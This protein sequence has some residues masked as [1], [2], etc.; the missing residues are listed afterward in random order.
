[1]NALAR[2]DIALGAAIA[3]VLDAG[4][5]L[6]SGER[7]S[8]LPGG[9]AEY[10]SVCGPD[11]ARHSGRRPEV[12]AAEGAKI[13]A[14]K[15]ALRARERAAVRILVGEHDMAAAPPLAE[16]LAELHFAEVAVGSSRADQLG[17]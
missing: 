13:L 15:I 11:R 1:M 14:R 6:R 5:E 2:Q 10:L 3:S 17:N 4:Q 9:Y 7:R 8:V 16:E 12:G